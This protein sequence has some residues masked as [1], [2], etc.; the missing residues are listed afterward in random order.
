[1]KNKY[2]YIILIFTGLLGFSACNDEWKDELYVQMVGLKA[3][4][5]YEDVSRI[6]LRYPENG[7]ISYQLPVVV[8]GSVT[9][10]RDIDVKIAVDNDTLDI[11]NKSKYTH[12]EDLFY[13]QLPESFYEFPSQTCL[14]P[15]GSNTELFE[16]KFNFKGLD[17]VEKWVLPLT[18]IEDPSY[19]MNMHKGWR[20]ALLHIVLFNNFSGEYSAT[21]MNVYF[22]DST[23][24][25]TNTAKRYSKVVDNN[26]IFFYAGITEELSED[27]G[28]YKIIAKFE[29][30]DVREAEG[31]L[32]DRKGNLTISADD[33]RIQFESLGQATYTIKERMDDVDPFLKR[34][35]I[36]MHLEYRYVDVTTAQVELPYTCKGTMLLERTIDTRVPDEDQAIRW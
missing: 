20:K 2:Y 33:S 35:S 9:N 28:I 34:R 23:S 36:T 25:P 26:T 21:G 15:S 27:R 22:K 14:V 11:L 32:Q 17:L 16:I 4:I 6:Y 8:S 29:D 10:K 31:E 30:P 18:I 12:R 13:K 7:E 19:I 5:N 24:E 3:V 1:M